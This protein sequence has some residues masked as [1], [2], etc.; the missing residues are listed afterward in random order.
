MAT[1]GLIG[2]G[3][4]GSAIARLAVAGGLDVVLSNSRGPQTLAGLVEE[5]GP[6]ARAA[7][8]LEA[9]EAGEWVVV[10][11]PVLAF[12]DVPRQPLVGKVV[13]D[14]C[15]YYPQRDGQIPELDE[16]K[17]TSSEILQRQL[18]GAHVVKVFNNI[19][20]RHLAALARPSGAP[21]RTALPIAGDDAGARTRATELID[22]LGY[23]VVDVGSLAD[24]WRFEPGRPSY[25]LPYAENPGPDFMTQPA[26]P[27]SAAD[28]KTL[29]AAAER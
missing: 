20:F 14:T 10:T 12:G 23:D 21:D 7:T 11:I 22:L 26:A 2:S 18:D 6:R 4:I 25:G 1:L 29:L 19:G 15:N 13:L 28:L 8:A 9:A 24:S 3:Y 27:L 5:L 16:G 17:V